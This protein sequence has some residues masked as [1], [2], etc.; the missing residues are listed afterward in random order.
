MKGFNKGLETIYSNSSTPINSATAVH[1]LRLVTDSLPVVGADDDSEALD[2][3]VVGIVLV[4]H[5]RQTDVLHA[6]G[7]GFSRRYPVQQG[8]IHAIVPPHVLAYLFEAIDRSRELL[9]EGLGIDPRNHNRSELADEIVWSVTS[10]RDAFDLP[11][12]FQDVPEIDRG[13]FPELAAFLEDA[14]MRRALDGFD[15][16]A[17]DIETVLERAW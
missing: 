8:V 15:P 3:A 14:L 16:N 12:R 2:R 17:T 11:T 1:R 13:D 10:V 7:H 5:K 6:F 4:Q 9:A